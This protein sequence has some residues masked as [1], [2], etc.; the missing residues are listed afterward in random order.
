MVEMETEL[1]EGIGEHDLNAALI[2]VEELSDFDV[3]QFYERRRYDRPR[4]FELKENVLEKRQKQDIP[5]LDEKEE[6]IGEIIE[7]CEDQYEKYL[8]N[9]PNY[10][11]FE[12]FLRSLPIEHVD[13]IRR[14]A[15][16]GHY[17]G[18]ASLEQELMNQYGVVFQVRDFN[19]LSDGVVRR[20]ESAMAQI[21]DDGMAE[22][23]DVFDGKLNELKR[24]ELAMEKRFV[25][26]ENG[27]KAMEESLIN[28]FA[29]AMSKIILAKNEELKNEKQILRDKFRNDLMEP[30]KNDV[31]AMKKDVFEIK[32]DVKEGAK[33]AF[34]ELGEGRTFSEKMKLLAYV[35]AG[36]IMSSIIT[37][38]LLKMAGMLH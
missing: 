4:T 7:H 28:N 12:S 19:N 24:R 16:D 36:G 23:E 20:V 30:I 31:L 32:N 25:Q 8:K 2:E 1:Q 38:G 37:V 10:R 6:M 15:Q 11:D 33:Q 35:A 22:I 17:Y 3:G 18:H 34:S 9:R 13:D 26:F 21:L 27:F 14:Y 29:S 5:D